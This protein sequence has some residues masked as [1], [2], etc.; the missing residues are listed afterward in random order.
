MGVCADAFGYTPE[1][2][3]RLT[4]PQLAALQRYLKERTEGVEKASKASRPSG[5]G[6]TSVDSLDQFVAMFGSPE[7]KAALRG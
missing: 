6:G 1:Q 7:A 5:S 4:L 3:Y 2:F